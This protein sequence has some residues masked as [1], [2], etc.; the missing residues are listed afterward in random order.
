MPVTDGYEMM[1]QV[2][3]G[4]GRFVPAVALTAGVAPE[5]VTAAFA[6]GYQKHLPKPVSAAALLRTAAELAPCRRLSE[7]PADDPT[8]HH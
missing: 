1:R 8:P 6:A 3:K 2:R 5:D 4:S 7:A